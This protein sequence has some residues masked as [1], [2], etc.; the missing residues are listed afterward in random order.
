[1]NCRMLHGRDKTLLTHYHK[2]F[3][4]LEI[5][6]VWCETLFTMLTWS[7]FVIVLH[8]FKHSTYGSGKAKFPHQNDILYV[9]EHQTVSSQGMF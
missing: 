1:M 3:E 4:Q 6:I 7:S 5:Y 8:T 9:E 2:N